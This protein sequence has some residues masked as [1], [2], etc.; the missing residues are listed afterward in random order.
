[1]NEL[2]NVK[3]KQTKSVARAHTHTHTEEANFTL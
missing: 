1:M 3:T 2:T